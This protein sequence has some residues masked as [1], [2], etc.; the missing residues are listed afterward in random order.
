MRT[1]G[2]IGGMS[3]ESTIPYYRFI[4]EAV[5]RK[6]G[7]FHSAKV[8]LYSVDFA[9]IEELQRRG[10][11]HRAG[12]LLAAA[13]RSVRAAGAEVLVL[14]TNTMHIVA[15]AI[16]RA[17]DVPLLHIVD[18]TA[19]A[20]VARECTIL[21]LL[22][23][24]FTMEEPFY[25]S[26]LEAL[27]GI[28]TLVPDERERNAVHA[29]IYDELCFGTIR[30]DSRAVFR[31]VMTNLVARGAQGIVFGCTEIAMLVSQ[32]DSS[33]PVFDTTRLHAEAAVASALA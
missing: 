10:D 2:L 28:R 25:A 24:R 22:G 7:G 17:V 27:H 18:P 32:A 21:G 23:T 31:D 9:E 3:W 20:A 19:R 26:R 29:I 12:A 11:W 30:E 15:P 4:N 14:C 1:I 16:E 13:A 33:V 5:K 6:L 8:V